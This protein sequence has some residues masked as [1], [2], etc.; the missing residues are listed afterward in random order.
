MLAVRLWGSFF[1]LVRLMEWPSKVC[2]VLVHPITGR[3][4]PEWGADVYLYTSFNFGARWWWMVNS[5]PRPL[6]PRGKT[7]YP[8]YRRLGGL[9][10]RPGRVRKISL[11]TVIRSP[12][13]PALS[14]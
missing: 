14:E 8:L 5:T 9:Q 6:H 11:P 10:G 3:E 13:R 12:N 7:R 1:N 2:F 4:V